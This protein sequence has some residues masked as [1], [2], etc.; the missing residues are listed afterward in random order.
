MKA[1]L[2]VGL[3]ACSA[4]AA[5][6]A[7]NARAEATSASQIV[8][9][10]SFEEAVRCFAT[11]AACTAELANCADAGVPQWSCARS[12]ATG[13]TRGP[14]DLCLPL[15]SLCAHDLEIPEAHR[16]PCRP[17]REVFCRGGSE[18][19]CHPTREIC[20]REVKTSISFGGEPSSCV[21][22]R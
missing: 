2:V 1:V 18:V 7:S 9:C 20:E 13:M 4:P 15:P 11:H 14:L 3:V 17:V 8:T 12:T 16:E 5:P 22:Y 21:R 19:I 10:G 6:V